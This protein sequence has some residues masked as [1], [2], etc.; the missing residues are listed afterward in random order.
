[1]R[2]RIR[3]IFPRVLSL[4]VLKSSYLRTISISVR[5][6]AGQKLLGRRMNLG[7]AVAMGRLCLLDRGRVLC[8][9][10]TW[11]IAGGCARQALRFCEAWAWCRRLL[12]EE[13]WFHASSWRSLLWHRISGP[14]LSRRTAS[15]ILIRSRK[16]TTPDRY[17]SSAKWSVH[18]QCAN[19][20]QASVGAATREPPSVD[21][22]RSR[23]RGVLYQ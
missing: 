17:D 15:L 9:E 5:M 23:P 2:C 1:M 16:E 20:D 21:R 18:F 19:F 3:H 11:R 8:H 10:G 6:I 22:R 4:R 7:E 14:T 12:E 13:I